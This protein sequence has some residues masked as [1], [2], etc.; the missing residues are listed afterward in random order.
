MKATIKAICSLT[1]L[2]L[3]SIAVSAQTN[4]RRHHKSYKGGSGTLE[5]SSVSG[6]V[7]GKKK[8]MRQEKKSRKKAFKASKNN[9]EGVNRKK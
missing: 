6:S 5:Q 8:I 4:P 3:L 2:L 7:H 1:F 9:R